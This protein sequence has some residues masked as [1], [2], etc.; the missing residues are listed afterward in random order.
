MAAGQRPVCECHEL[1]AC[2]A[3]GFNAGS[4]LAA[5]LL[6]LADPAKRSATGMSLQAAMDST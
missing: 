5:N 6:T 3:K 2:Y 4:Q 1:C